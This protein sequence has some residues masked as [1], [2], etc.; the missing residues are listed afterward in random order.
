MIL[1]NNYALLTARRSLCGDPMPVLLGE[2]RSLCATLRLARRFISS[3]EHLWVERW[4]F[5]ACRFG[6]ATR[7]AVRRT[8]GSW[9]ENL[10]VKLK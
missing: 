6:A 2:N 4:T 8:T 7:T 9:P 5:G 10:V 1:R 3:A